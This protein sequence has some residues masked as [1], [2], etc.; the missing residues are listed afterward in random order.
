MQDKD[1]FLEHFGVKGMKWGIRKDVKRG[2]T[3]TAKKLTNKELQKR[4]NRLSMEKKYAELEQGRSEAS[5]S[6]G[7]KIVEGI[8]ANFGGHFTRTLTKR[9]AKGSANIVANV[10]GGEVKKRTG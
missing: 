7:Q 10:L 2:A 6:E 1:N 3:Q 9:A 5:K 8:V 4:V